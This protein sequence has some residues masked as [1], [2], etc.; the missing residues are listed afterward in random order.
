ML[1]QAGGLRL[2]A[3]YLRALGEE[4]LLL[5]ALPGIAAGTA[6]AAPVQAQPASLPAAHAEGNE[7][8][9]QRSQRQRNDDGS[10]L[11]VVHEEAEQRGV[12]LPRVE[13]RGE[14]QR[15]RLWICRMQQSENKGVDASCWRQ[16]AE[17]N[18]IKCVSCQRLRTAAKL[19]GGLGKRKCS[20]TN[21]VQNVQGKEHPQQPE[22]WDGEDNQQPEASIRAELSS[23]GII[24]VVVIAGVLRE[25]SNPGDIHEREDGSQQRRRPIDDKPNGQWEGASCRR[26]AVQQPEHQLR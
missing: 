1:V 12:A 3:L 21:A 14:K 19:R 10:G 8:G 7:N 22:Q 20:P 5:L 4:R 6:A 11:H 18:A 9:D 26:V 24:I 17:V 15:Q 13:G 2:S 25:S 23:A 16:G